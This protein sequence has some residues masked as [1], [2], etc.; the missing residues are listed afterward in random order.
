[1][2][3]TEYTIALT[4]IV[5]AMLCGC[6]SLETTGYAPVNGSKIAY[7]QIGNGSPTV[8]FQAGLGDDKTVWKAVIH[9]LGPTVSIFTYDRPGYG[10]SP[11]TSVARD[12]CSIAREQR[13]LLEN[14]GIKPPYILV[15]HSLGGL[16]EYVYA[17]LYPEDVAGIVLLD[18]THPDHLRRMQEE[19]PATASVLK[20]T[21]KLFGT[22][23]RHEFDAQAQCLDMAVKDTPL[24]APSQLLIRSEF[25]LVEKG[26]FEAVI[27]SLAEDWQKLTGANR[28][29]VVP[30]SGHYIQKDRPDAVIKAIRTLLTDAQKQR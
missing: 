18:P 19:V 23:M 1:M 9:M 11:A 30:K 29:E 12:P 28:V 10:E 15:G 2:T 22:T 4:S 5:F 16:Y 20:A 24:Q 3:D 7:S 25:Q 21:S 14:V 26:K 13:L 27:H 8:V 17:H 6:A